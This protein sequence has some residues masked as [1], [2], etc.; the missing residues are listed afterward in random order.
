MWNY[1]SQSLKGKKTPLNQDYLAVNERDGNILALLCDGMGGASS[2][3]VA[4]RLCVKSMTDSFM[5]EYD[6]PYNREW[7][8]D[9]VK[10][11]NRFLYD[12]S[13]IHTKCNG[14]GTTMTSIMIK[15]HK[16]LVV[17]VGDSRL[18]RFEKDELV[19]ITEDDSLIW[20]M[21]KQGKLKKE[22]MVKHPSGH[23][24]TRHMAMDRD[25]EVKPLEIEL[26]KKQLFLL[27][28]DGV[29]DY[30]SD[31]KLQTLIDT[32]LSLEEIGQLIIEEALNEDSKDDLSII[33][34]S[35]YLK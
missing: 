35:S 3:E 23:L 33:L 5:E 9:I 1:F 20:E 34:L 7:L 11:A 27:C 22:Q 28:S 30:V 25:I 13:V 8:I 24:I 10:E 18:Y 2:G 4:S 16:A 32:K 21:Y 31:A 17:N 19:Q 12:Y 26:T 29:T 14:M 6:P 15:D